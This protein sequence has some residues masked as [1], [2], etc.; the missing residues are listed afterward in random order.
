MRTLVT[1]GAGFIGSHLVDALAA[2][3]DEVSVV[4]DLSTGR[5]ETLEAALARGA[6]V[7]RVDIRDAE[8]LAAAV[9]A[10]RPDAILHLAAQM[11]VRRS[12]ADPAFDARTNI[13][14]TI[15][16]LEAARAAGARVVNVS[17]GGAMY[18]DVDTIP[19]PETV[20]PL[21]EAPYGQ[22]KY[23]AERYVRL[24]ERLHGVRGVTLR[25]GNVYGPR[26]DPHGEAGV[27]A[28]FCG[29]VDRGERPTVYGAGT[30]TRDYVYVADV[31]DGLL[32]ALDRRDA[33]RE[34]NVGTGRA[35]S[36]LDIVAA[37]AP[38]AANGFAP[39][40]ADARPGEIEHSCLD[41]ARAR[42]EL[43][44][45][46]RIGLADGLRRTLAWTR[47]RAAAPVAA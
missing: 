18:G 45:T 22:S 8:T 43:G 42:A 21:P 46:A 36:V 9:A 38:H 35:S 47:E 40:F 44:F 5:L 29:L 20:E 17:T 30:Q 33:A 24:Y 39:R 15:N 32:A 10:A 3:G 27:V 41:V 6:A 7:H 12:V 37:L 28:I 1:G 19:T 4:D 23:C 14:G 2:R 16:V 34:Y 13:E 11:D 26:Q 25:L 31:V